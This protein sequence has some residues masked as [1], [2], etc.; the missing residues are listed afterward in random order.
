MTVL[1]HPVHFD[2][3]EI[4]EATASEKTPMPWQTTENFSL[5]DAR[6]ISGL[7]TEFETFL[8]FSRIT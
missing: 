3:I 5:E 8:N 2:C 6:V 1:G 7:Q 4:R